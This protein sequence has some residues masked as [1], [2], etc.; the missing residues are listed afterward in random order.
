MILGKMSNFRL[1]T[2]V[3]VVKKIVNNYAVLFL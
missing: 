3:K 1:L 2:V